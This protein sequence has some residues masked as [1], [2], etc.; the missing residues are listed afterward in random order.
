MHFIFQFTSSSQSIYV[1]DRP[2]YFLQVVTPTA[3]IYSNI[4]GALRDNRLQEFSL[5]VGTT[6]AIA[7]L[8]AFLA[9]WNVVLDKRS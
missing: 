7:V 5:L 9:R 4:E 2:T 6:A 1:A 8:I 3:T